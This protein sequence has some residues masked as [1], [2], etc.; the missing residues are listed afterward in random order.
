MNERGN[1]EGGAKNIIPFLPRQR[2]ETEHHEQSTSENNGEPNVIDLSK[3]RQKDAPLSYKATHKKLNIL[4]PNNDEYVA[5][6]RAAYHKARESQ[7]RFAEVSSKLMQELKDKKHVIERVIFEKIR[8]SAESNT[9]IRRI[10]ICV[11]NQAL[12]ND[13]TPDA[14]LRELFSPEVEQVLGVEGFAQVCNSW[15]NS[16]LKKIAGKSLTIKFD[17]PNKENDTTIPRALWFE[18]R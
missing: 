3:N 9:S 5:R 16:F 12:Q 4:Q 8:K 15:G 13:E 6:E 7:P 1:G 18:V 11:G 14:A 2:D 10:Y 17:S